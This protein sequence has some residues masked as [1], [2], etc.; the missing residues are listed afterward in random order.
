[1]I[2][3]LIVEDSASIG[4]VLKDILESDAGIR[5]TAVVESGEDALRFLH[6]TKTKP[7]VITMDILMSGMDGFAATQ[8]IME[9]CPVPIIIVSSPYKLNE[10]ENSFKAMEAGAVAIIEKPVDPTHPDYRRI[11]SELIRTVKN[12]SEVKV[13]TRFSQKGRKTFPGI[14]PSMAPGMAPK[15]VNAVLIGASTGG[16]PVLLTILSGLPHNLPVPLL[17]VQHISAGF[18]E[19]LARWLEVITGFPVHIPND[20]DTCLPGHV[21]LAPNHVHMGM[22]HGY[23]VKLE[24]APE[25]NGQRPSVSY[26]FR[27]AAVH[28]PGSTIGILLTGMG[29]DGSAELKLMKNTGSI[30]IAQDEASCVVYGMPGEAVKLGGATYVLSP[31]EIPRKIIDVINEQKVHE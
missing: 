10:A 16:P 8:R 26:L 18:I 9:I 5:V 11:A 1:M 6:S 2:R 3:V 13:V 31:T 15:G 19:G 29:K 25:E 20:G 7:D 30:T 22:T 28:F 21:Y 12:M 17:I 24:V 23:R 4:L 14:I 27:S